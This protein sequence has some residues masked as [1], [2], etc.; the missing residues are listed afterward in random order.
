[1]AAIFGF[2]SQKN[3]DSQ[4]LSH[5]ISDRVESVIEKN[6][7]QTFETEEARTEYFKKLK[8]TLNTAVRKNAHAFLFAAFGLFAFLLFVQEGRCDY[9]AAIYTL[10]FGMLYASSDELHQRFVEARNG[11]FQDVCI[12]V[13][14]VAAVLILIFFIRTARQ[15]RHCKDGTKI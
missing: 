2:S 5:A 1:M 12:D 4:T 11:Q 6:S 15:K 8:D 10:L 13:F 9:A 7:T 14:G 3:D